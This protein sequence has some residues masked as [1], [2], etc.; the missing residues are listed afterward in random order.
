[1]FGFSFNGQ[2]T[3]KHTTLKTRWQFYR[4]IITCAYAY[5]FQCDVHVY[6]HT[7][8]SNHPSMVHGWERDAD[9]NP[10]NKH[11]NGW[12]CPK[13]NSTDKMHVCHFYGFICLFIRWM[14][15]GGFFS[16]WSMHFFPSSINSFHNSFDCNGY[17]VHSLNLMVEFD[18]RQM[19]CFVTKHNQRTNTV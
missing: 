5:T 18:A 11:Y 14:G 12:V 4:N 17:I 15:L 6:T 2:P 9:I 10:K 3:K 13:T 1:M 16:G 19:Q 8:P 7:K